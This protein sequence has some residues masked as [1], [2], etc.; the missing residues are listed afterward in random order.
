MAAVPSNL[1]RLVYRG[2]N[3]I[4]RCAAEGIRTRPGPPTTVDTSGCRNDVTD[5][6][7]PEM[8]RWRA[9]TL[10][11]SFV[12]GLALSCQGSQPFQSPPWRAPVPATGDGCVEYVFDR[13][14]C[15]GRTGVL[16]DREGYERLV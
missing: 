6:K 5:Y 1:I 12:L 13:W 9:A 8:K 16:L 10:A 4:G 14:E 15:P 11:T 2:L 7:R 3:Y